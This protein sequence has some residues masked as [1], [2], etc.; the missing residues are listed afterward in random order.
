[1]GTCDTVMGG[2]EERG[3]PGDPPRDSRDP[4]GYG[5]HPHED[6]KEVACGDTAGGDHCHCWHVDFLI[7]SYPQAGK[8]ALIRRIDK[9]DDTTSGILEEQAIF[10]KDLKRIRLHQEDYEAKLEK[11]L[12]QQQ[13]VVDNM[14]KH[15]ETV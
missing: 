9:R 15:L 11:M 2:G 5:C 3:A 13:G 1:M 10:D 6:A 14:R 8:D 12:L 4:E 7:G